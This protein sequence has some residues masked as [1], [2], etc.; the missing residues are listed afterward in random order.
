M[1]RQRV[2]YV[3]IQ[4][5]QPALNYKKSNGLGVIGGKNFA[6]DAAGVRSDFAS[7]LIAADTK[8]ANF[9][10]YVQSV[11]IA[12]GYHVIAGPRVYRFVPGFAGARFGTW[13]QIATLTP[14]QTPTLSSIPEYLR[15]FT[16]FYL[17]GYAYVSHWNYGTYRVNVATG[18]YTRLTSLTTPGFP[19][20]AEPVYGVAES[21][22]RAVYLTKTTAYWSAPAD[23]ENLVPALGG[24]GFQ[25]L[26]ERIAGEPRTILRVNAGIVIWTTAGALAA[27]FTAN[28]AVFRLSLIHI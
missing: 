22:G 9:G 18:A 26:G 16:S 6:W 8:I 5:L 23:P 10:E 2:P 15:A 24:A 21:N 28:D 1:P 3:E 25:I 12:D 7:R 11:K 4:S 20:D 27:E 19:S 17:A 14:V 13:E